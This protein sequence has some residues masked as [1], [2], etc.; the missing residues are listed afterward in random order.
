VLDATA[1]ALKFAGFQEMYFENTFP[2]EFGVVPKE[3][4]QNRPH[5]II[6]RERK[7]L[8]TDEE[9]IRETAQNIARFMDLAEK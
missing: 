7:D 9:Y 3:S 4:L 1:H 8:L 6:A 5:T 2:P